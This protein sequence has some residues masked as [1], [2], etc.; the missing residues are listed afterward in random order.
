MQDR[1]LNTPRNSI[2]K[3]VNEKDSVTF[4]T[5]NTNLV[6]VYKGCCILI[7]GVFMTTARI[8]VY[9]ELVLWLPSRM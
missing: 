8:M 7:I 3:A 9:L 1:D 6:T 4:T 2:K 5:S